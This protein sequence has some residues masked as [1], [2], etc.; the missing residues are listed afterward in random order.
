[1]P[2][3]LEK[4][5]RRWYAVLDVPKDL[6]SKFGGKP[7]FVQSLQTESLSVAEVRVLPLVADWKRA[8]ADARGQD[9]ASRPAL[10]AKALQWRDDLQKSQHDDDV[11]FEVHSLI[12][13][14][15][16]ALDHRDRKS[17]EVAAK[18][19][20]GESYPLDRDVEAW[21][22]S[23]EVEPKTRDMKRSDVRRFL[24]RFKFSH[25]VTRSAVMT[26]AHNLQASDG[27]KPATVR[28]IISACRG[29]WD[30]LHTIGHLSDQEAA[31]DKVSPKKPA[32]TKAAIKDVRQA[33]LAD[34]IPRLL[35]GALEKND[36]ELAQ[37]IWLAVWTGCRIEEL[38]SLKVGDVHANYFAVTDAK[39]SAGLREVP[40]HPR[41]APLLNHLCHNSPDGYVL[42]SLTFNKYD[43]RSNAIGKRFG[44]LKSSLGFD[45]RFVFHSLRKTVTTELENAG[46]PENVAA[47]IVGHDK[48]TITY[49]LYSK[50]NK[51]DVLQQAIRKLRYNIAPQIERNLY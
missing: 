6:R 7:R 44:R 10:V 43:D 22:A 26:W 21:I 16:I 37:L 25:E 11:A 19:A 35:V 33:F 38:C 3:Y 28:R 5:R 34:D 49:G 1:M 50:G 8:I 51:L 4:R 47:D 48:K 31:F 2:K 30:Y 9:E 24:E 41:L 14:E 12:Q 18:I 29:Y 32:K 27:L 36:K 46:V 17:A 23:Q 42:P 39:T 15:L 45:H 20:Y 40:I 13:D